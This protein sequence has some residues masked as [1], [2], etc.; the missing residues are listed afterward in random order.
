MVRTAAA[1]VMSSYALPSLRAKLST[2]PYS[3]PPAF[4]TDDRVIPAE[5]LTAVLHVLALE[6]IARAD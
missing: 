1:G 3:S 5:S 2:L 4:V 6:E